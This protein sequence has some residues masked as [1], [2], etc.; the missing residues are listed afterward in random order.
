MTYKVKWKLGKSIYTTLFG[1]EK[2]SGL[3]DA[4]EG[5]DVLWAKRPDGTFVIRGGR[6][7]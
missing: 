3:L 4:L 7:L 6:I 5:Y 1:F 2:S